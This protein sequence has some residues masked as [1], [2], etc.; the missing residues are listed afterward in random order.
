MDIG[1]RAVLNGKGSKAE[2]ITRT[3]A[4]EN[5]TIFTRGKMEGNT[6]DCRGHLECRGLILDE[7]ALLWAVPELVAKR[8]GAE[9]THEAAVGKI[10][11]NEILYLMT[12][13][14][15]RDQAVSLIIRGFM[16]VGI[17]GLPENISTEINRIIEM[18]TE[19]S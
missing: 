10:S 9:L 14:L 12:R 16:N 15:S 18:V 11:E 19:A 1:S 4:R 2:L 7:E 17:M 6:A 5:A 3:I 13:R 8:R